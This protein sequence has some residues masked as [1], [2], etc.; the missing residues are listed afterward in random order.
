MPL[1]EFALGE[2]RYRI[3]AKANPEASKK[4]IALAD[5]DNKTKF[6]NLEFLASKGKDA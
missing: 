5:A 2:N 1:E 4:L 3:L 6:E